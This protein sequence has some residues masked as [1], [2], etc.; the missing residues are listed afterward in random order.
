VFDNTTMRGGKFWAKMGSH[1]Y[2]CLLAFNRVLNKMMKRMGREKIPLSKQVMKRVNESIIKIERFETLVADLAIEKKYDY[3]ICGHIHQPQ[4]RIISNKHG[5]VVYLN[6]GDWVEHLSA[7][8][9]YQ[10]DWHIYQYEESK[11]KTVNVKQM[12]LNVAD[13]ITDEIAIYLHS[14][15][16]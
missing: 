2:A 6:S 11:L 12:K 5:K 15:G 8:E 10:G 7:L 1:G 3:V 13:V 4:K 16:A 9:Y 14:L